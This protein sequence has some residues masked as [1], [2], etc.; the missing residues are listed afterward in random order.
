L[1]ELRRLNASL[2]AQLRNVEEDCRQIK[3]QMSILEQREMALQ[4]EAA[5]LV[6]ERDDLRTRGDFVQRLCSDLQI[7]NSAL[8]EQLNELRGRG[9]AIERLH[10]ELDLRNHSLEQQLAAM[11]KSRSWRWTAP[12]RRLLLKMGKP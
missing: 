4:K 1:D 9:E 3:G 6:R 8:E 11:R 10:A 12:V 5:N 7:R 2:E